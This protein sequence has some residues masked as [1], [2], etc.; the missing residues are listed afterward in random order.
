MFENYKDC[1]FNV[2]KF[3]SIG[4]IAQQ[5]A[6]CVLHIGG[7]DST[8]STAGSPKQLLEATPEYRTGT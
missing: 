2:K 7:Q 4:E 1:I 6:V 5:V 8:P 3:S